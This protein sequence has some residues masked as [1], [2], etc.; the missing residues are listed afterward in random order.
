VTVQDATPQAPSHPVVV[1]MIIIAAD[2]T[3]GT[4]WTPHVA[5]VAAVEMCGSVEDV[6]IRLS[7]RA[8]QRPLIVGLPSASAA[9][10]AFEAGARGCLFGT[11]TRVTAPPANGPLSK[12]EIQ[13]LQGLADGLSTRGLAGELGLSPQTIKSH[14]ARITTRLEACNRVH[15]V[16]IA[17][18]L[19]LIR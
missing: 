18:R 5:S 8:T 16:L 4:A 14:M 7:D 9:V 13:V 1:R 12:R 10:T 17:F 11:S 19:G 6:M 3:T 15:A 2:P